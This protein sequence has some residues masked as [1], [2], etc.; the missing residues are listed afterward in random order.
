MA[1]SKS[2]IAKVQTRVDSWVN[3]LTGLGDALRD[4]RKFSVFRD[5]APLSTD[6]L[7]WLYHG[8]DVAAR[9]VDQ[10]PYDGFRRWFKVGTDDDNTDFNDLIQEELKRLKAKEKLKEAAIWGR[11]FGGAVVYMGINDGQTQDQPV[12]VEAIRSIEFLTVLDCRDIKPETF[13]SSLERYGEPETYKIQSLQ[14]I[15]GQLVETA[16]T[17]IHY[18]RL[19]IFGGALTARK[20]KARNSGWDDSVLQK[21]HEVISNFNIG[22]Q[23][24]AHLL[25]DASQ[26]VFK[27]EGLI[28]MIAGGDKDT[29]QARM[30][31]VEMSRSIAR[32]IM[33]DAEKED[34]TRQNYTFTGIPEVLQAFML[35]LA[36]AAKMPVTILMGQ[37]PAGMN[38]TGESDIRLW[39][40]SVESWQEEKLLPQLETLVEYVGAANGGAPDRF[41]IIFN[42][43]W[44]MTDLEQAQLEKSV[45]EKDAIYIDKGVVLPDEVALSRFTTEGFSMHTQIDLEAR[46]EMLQAEVDLAK[47]QAGQDPIERAQKMAQATAGD[48]FGGDSGD[49]EKTEE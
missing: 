17:P 4:K 12:N 38:A 8:E 2:L 36:S 6:K 9:I 35:R 46:E 43:L 7:E 22:W 19:L 13:S 28:Q 16:A 49:Q 11:L 20:R 48:S 39:Y 42:R 18:S 27:I 29:L 44:Q 33:L 15:R 41:E 25:E 10:L 5:T 21:T 31:T 37:S 26:A 23:G 3:T 24:T 1:E 30:E 45:A 34:F 40:D 47:E 32:A 14:N